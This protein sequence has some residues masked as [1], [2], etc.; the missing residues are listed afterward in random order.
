MFLTGVEMTLQ[1]RALQF[2]TRKH[3]EIKQKRKYTGEDYITHPMA[4]AEIIM[5]IEHTPEMIAAA[6]LHDTVKDTNTTLNEIEKEFGLTVAAYVECL[7]DISVMSDGNRA[8]RKEID[9]Q[10]L[11]H[12][13]PCVQS[14]KLADLIHNSKTIVKFDPEFTRVYIKEKSLLLEVLK[15]GD[16]YLWE[17]AKA[18]V[19]KNL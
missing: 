18:I 13:P 9:R 3:G 14:I 19:D 11:S 1:E 7:T 15:G 5:G 8:T 2:T 4:V 16:S 6:Y 17:E 12:A 10:H